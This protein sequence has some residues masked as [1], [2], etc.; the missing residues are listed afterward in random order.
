MTLEWTERPHHPQAMSDFRAVLEQAGRHPSERY[1]ILKSIVL[2]NLYGVDI[3]E[4]AVEI[5]KLRL[6]L[7]LVAQLE[8]YDQIEPLPDIDFNIRA[9]NTLVGFTSLEAV[10][11]AMTITPGGQHRQM[12]PEEQET[13]NRIEEEAEIASSAFNQFRR[14]QTML[15]GEVTAAAKTDLKRRQE[16]LSHELNRYLAAEYGVNVKDSKAYDRWQASHQPFHWFVEFYGIMS[17]GG[18][19]VVVDNPPYVS[20]RKVAEWYTPKGFQTAGC[21]DIYATVVERSV[22]VCRTDGRTSMIVPLSL[23]FS[24]GFASLRSHL[25]QEC[26]SIWFSS[27]GRIPSALFSFDTRVRNTIYLARKSSRSPK[28]SFTTRLHRWFDSQRPALFESLSYSPFSPAAFDGL[29]P[30]VGS[31]RL[32]RGLESLLDDGTYRLQNGFAP[33]RQGHHLDFKQTAY[34][35]VTFCV[36]QPPVY[37]SDNNIIPQTKYGTVRFRDAGYR[38]ISMLLLNGKLAFV[39]WMAIGDDFDLTRSNFASAP[40]G[41]D[42]LSQD[43]RTYLSSLLPELEQAMNKNLVFKL[44]AG[45]NIGNYNLAR[46][47]HVTDKIDKV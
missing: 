19:D 26:D 12:F 7:K 25:Q 41:A 20:R 46:C 5:C 17:K 33:A 23:T 13:L 21:P 22:N 42:Q 24:S 11:S 27:F 39:W 18:F 30:K 2:N 10:R 34:N 14:Q 3:M 28:R 32:L 31:A 40:F 8:T 44:N 38:D 36:D 16:S 6:F 1:Y 15:G 9:G 47:R 4:E 45:K 37:D 29:V 43:Q 35:W